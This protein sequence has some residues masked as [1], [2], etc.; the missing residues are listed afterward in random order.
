MKN[1]KLIQILKTFDKREFKEFEK[2]VG[3]PFHNEGRNNLPLVKAIKRY[4]PQFDKL[5]FNKENIFYE[6]Y[7][8]KEYKDSIMDTLLSRTMKLAEKYLVFKNLERNPS[9]Y[10]IMLSDELLER[11]LTLL[12]RNKANDAEG[13]ISKEGIERYNIY[14]LHNTS[15]LKYQIN[16]I[17][18][19]INDMLKNFN[20]LCSYFMMYMF[21]ELVNE[22]NAIHAYDSLYNTKLS[23][24]PIYKFIL[25]SSF[26]KSIDGLSYEDKNIE[27]IIEMYYFLLRLLLDK[28]NYD[29]FDKAKELFINCLNRLTKY[30]EYVVST[31]LINACIVFERKKQTYAYERFKLHK[32]TLEMKIYSPYD[33]S[34]LSFDK[35][36]NIVLIALSFKELEWTKNFINEYLHE[37][38]PEQQKNM[39]NYSYAHYYFY[40]KDFNKS[41]EYLSKVKLDVFSHKEDVK[42]LQLMVYFEQG[43]L[44]ESYY[45]IDTF[46]HFLS[47]NP[48]VTEDTR[49]K[50][51]DFIKTI[52]KLI[53]LREN[54]EMAQ[55][56][57]FKNELSKKRIP[58]KEWF[59]EKA[60][61]LEK[62]AS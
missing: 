59:I 16:S 39:L 3:S 5:N 51:K 36:R 57:Q 41:L 24:H 10:L 31:L 12:S 30:E 47:E 18:N 6:L 32:L 43:R 49:V 40:D 4:Y 8:S 53:K 7:P 25:N 9:Q 46:K 34:P 38:P 23:N 27:Q 14:K 33:N 13:I 60:N 29:A 37:L 54:K 20:D 17:E 42:R 58:F 52:S 62:S 22:V 48:K 56:I 2:F 11:K 45:L 44:E 55:L 19:N 28:N 50:I 26:E 1:H 21:M 35:F 15:Y 61:E